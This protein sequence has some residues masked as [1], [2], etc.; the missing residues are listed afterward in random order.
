MYLHEAMRQPDREKFIE[1]MQKEVE[2]QMSN[3]NF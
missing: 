3:G 2:D 1:A